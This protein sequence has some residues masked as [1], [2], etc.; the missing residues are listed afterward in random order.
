MIGDRHEQKAGAIIFLPVSGEG[1]HK[2]RRVT[3]A[4]LTNRGG[5]KEGRDVSSDLETFLKIVGVHKMIFPPS[6][7]TKKML[8]CSTKKGI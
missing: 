5:H 1:V 4:Q 6:S 8:E 2:E 3:P 7:P